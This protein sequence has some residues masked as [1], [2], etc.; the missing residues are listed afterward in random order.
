MLFVVPGFIGVQVSMHDGNF[1][2]LPRNN[3]GE[4]EDK[5]ECN[6]ALPSF[7]GSHMVWS[8]SKDEV[9]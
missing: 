3:E 1:P 6:Q 9:K 7:H 2:M 8:C 5:R 4:E